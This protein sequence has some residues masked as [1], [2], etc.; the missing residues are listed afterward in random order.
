MFAML[1]QIAKVDV[2][3][4]GL[5]FL[6]LGLA[7]FGFLWLHYPFEVQNRNIGRL[8]RDFERGRIK[9]S[10]VDTPLKVSLDGASGVQAVL[11]RRVD[12]VVRQVQG[13]VV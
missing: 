11:I 6:L 1:L 10:L 7:L 8:F 3:L 13:Q 5:V 9:L 4:P 12:G 2:V